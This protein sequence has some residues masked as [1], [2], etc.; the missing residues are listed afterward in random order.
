MSGSWILNQIFLFI[1]TLFNLFSPSPSIYFANSP[2]SLSSF[3]Y[4]LTI[5]TNGVKKKITFQTSPTTSTWLYRRGASLL[6]LVIPTLY[7][8]LTQKPQELVLFLLRDRHLNFQIPTRIQEILRDQSTPYDPPVGHI[9]VL[10][11]CF[12]RAT[13]P[14]TLTCLMAS[15]A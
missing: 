4:F 1:L 13:L 5:Q 9:Q 14:F 8:I 7:S 11:C 12:V 15:Y 3:S 2:L 10:N 6:I